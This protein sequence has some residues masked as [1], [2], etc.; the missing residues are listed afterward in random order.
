[1]ERAWSAGTGRA[2]T[3]RAGTGREG[4]NPVYSIY[5][6]VLSYTFIYLYI[7]SNTPKYLYI[8][9]YAPIYIK[10]S[11]IRKMRSNLRPKNC[12]DSSSRVSP[13]VRIWHIGSD[14]VPRGSGT[15][16][17]TEFELNS[18]VLDGFRGVIKVQNPINWAA[19]SS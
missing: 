18:Q 8:P 6:Y 11:N 14:H 5:L 3:G 13:R 17:G 7:P 4:D 19:Y 1:M 10:I 15:P 9:F 2:G 12:H 16:K